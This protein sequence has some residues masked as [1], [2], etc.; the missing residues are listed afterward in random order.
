MRNLFIINILFFA[1]FFNAT[2]LVAQN[3]KTSVSIG[4]GKFFNPTISGTSKFSFIVSSTTEKTTQ[5]SPVTTL[6]LERR[7]LK[8]FS[9][10]LNYNTLSA[11]SERVTNTGAFLLF[12]APPTVSTEKISS[13]ISGISGN[14]KGF[15]YNDKVFQVYV[16][17]GLGLLKNTETIDE[18]LANANNLDE[19]KISQRVENN[20]A[21]MAEINVGV[22]IFIISNVGIYGEIG[23]TSI[24]GMGGTSSQLGVICRF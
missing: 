19:Q 14:L 8:H 17:T 9:F 13:K 21:M 15:V 4:Q 3:N 16:Q 20:I 2:G 23:R 5:F 11:Q 1:S 6:K 22:R 18:V 24:S 10:G 7:F 12:F